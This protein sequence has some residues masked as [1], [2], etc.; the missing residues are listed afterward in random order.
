MATWTNEEL[1]AVG[2]AEE[3]RISSRR[4]DGTLRKP[5]IIWAVQHGDD[6]YVRSVNGPTASWYR[7]T[8]SSGEGQIT[9]GGV[10]RDVSFVTPDSDIDDALNAEYR[11]KYGRY[12][13]SIIDSINSAQAR[14]AT[15][16]IVPRDE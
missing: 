14:S 3:L 6:L 15:I 9:A 7:G 12:A 5:V 16:K 11:A 8:Q 13:A 4:R 10:E 2:S 1:N